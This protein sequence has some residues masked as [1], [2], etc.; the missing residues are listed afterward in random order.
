[1]AAQTNNVAK[2]QIHKQEKYKKSQNPTMHVMSWFAT[3]RFSNLQLSSRKG[4]GFGGG[5][6]VLWKSYHSKTPP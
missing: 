3:P 5:V 1:M 2:R 4:K 6:Y